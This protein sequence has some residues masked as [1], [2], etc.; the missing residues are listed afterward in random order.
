V[1]AA[2]GDLGMLPVE[3]QACGTPVLAYGAGGSRETVLPPG[4]AQGLPPT[5]LFF[6]EQSVESLLDGLARFEQLAFD[7]AAC[8]SWAEGFSRERFHE[9][10]RHEISALVRLNAAHLHVH[11][12][13]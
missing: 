1:F 5:G 9:T 4:N 6:A 3:A 7:P 2:A 13:R 8:R 12:G 11:S 10:M